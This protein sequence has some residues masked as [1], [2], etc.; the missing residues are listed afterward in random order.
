MYLF[1]N[2]HACFVYCIGCAAVQLYF[3]LFRG[4]GYDVAELFHQDFF[5]IGKQRYI[6][7]FGN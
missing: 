3:F 7:T 2:I 1:D 4:M 6:H 5:I